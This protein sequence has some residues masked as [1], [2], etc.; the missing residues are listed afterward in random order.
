MFLWNGE[1]VSEEE[2]QVS[3]NDR[4]YYFGDGVYE[5][6]RIYR[7]QLFEKQAHMKRLYQSMHLV[8]IHVPW[9]E[10]ALAA[11]L[12]ELAADFGNGDGYLYLQITRGAAP[13]THTI[14]DQ[15]D[16][17]MLGY[18]E[19]YASPISQ[20]KQ[21]I[22]AMTTEDIRWHQCNIKSLNLLPNTLARQQAKEAGAEEAIFIREGMVTEG[23]A[24]NLF[25]VT[26]GVIRTHPADR[27]ILEG[28]TRQ[29]IE[30]IAE[31]EGIPFENTACSQ[32]ELMAADEVFLTSTTRE[33]TP[34]IS[35]DNQPIGSGTPGPVTR[36][37]QE[38]FNRFKLVFDRK[39]IL[40]IQ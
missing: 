18:C 4:G 20:I 8:R 1:L 29:V 34:V 12:D 17:V 30:R 9:D 22:P 36:Q 3:Y 6:F 23:S 13:R 28:I 40:S 32:D 16:P 14:P 35:I 24:S 39:N 25:I 10:E 31:E 27:L 19:P 33:I 26:G 7:G 2:I 15:I 38:A 11:K 21:G 5:V 37:L